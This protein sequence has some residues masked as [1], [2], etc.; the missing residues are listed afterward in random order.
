M[1]IKA[2]CCDAEH[3]AMVGMSSSALVRRSGVDAY[4]QRR[5]HRQWR[6]R[7]S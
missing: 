7:G 5:R 1:T 3:P 6:N 4:L 2:E